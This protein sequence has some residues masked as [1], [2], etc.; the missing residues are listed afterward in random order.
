MFLHIASNH[1]EL[2]H[3]VREQKTCVVISS[4]NCI[5]F[6]MDFQMQSD[7]SC[8]RKKQQPLSWTGGDGRSGNHYYIVTRTNVNLLCWQHIRLFASTLSPLPNLFFFS[9]DLPSAV[10][11]WPWHDQ[12]RAAPKGF[13]TGFHAYLA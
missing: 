10:V 7:M 11:S 2:C 8:T 13:L 9:T 1:I 12:G 6:F 5:F 4:E 3:V